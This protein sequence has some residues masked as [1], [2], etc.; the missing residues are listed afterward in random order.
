M[1]ETHYFRAAVEAAARVR[2]E[3]GLSEDERI[4]HAHELVTSQLPSPSALDILRSSLGEFKTLYAEHPAEAKAL[5]TPLLGQSADSKESVELA[6]W[7]LLI[8]SLLN[9]D[10]TKTRQ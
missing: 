7:T 9:L 3:A 8:H 2:R 1:N 6:A 10:I 5:A 4:R